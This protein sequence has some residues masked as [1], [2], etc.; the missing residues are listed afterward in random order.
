[1]ID[2]VAFGSFFN[3]NSLNPADIKSTTVLKDATAT[4]IYGS[5]GANGVVLITTKNGGSLKKPHE[6]SEVEGAIIEL[7]LKTGINQQLIP[8]YD[9]ITSPEEYV[10]LVW[11]GL[12]NRGV[13][14]DEEDPV[15]FANSRLLGSNGI[16]DGYNMWNVSSAAELID[17]QTRTV[18]PGVR[19]LFTPEHYADEAFG[20]GVRTEANINVSGASKKTR[21]YTSIGYLNDEGYSINSD[22]T[23]YSLRLNT[24]S[25]L[26]DWLNVGVNIGY[27]YSESTNNGQIQGSENVFEFADKMAPI[28]P[29][30]ARLPGTGTLIPDPVYGGYQYDYGS[31]TGTIN[32]FERSRPNANLLN[33]IGSARFDF[34]GRTTNALNGSVFTH[35]N[36]LSDLKLETTFGGQYSFNRRQN[37]SNHVYGTGRNPNGTLEVRDR[38]RWSRT[39]TNLLR[40]NKSFDDHTIEGLVAYETFEVGFSQSRQ[41]KKDVIV[42]GLYNLSNYSLT[43]SPSDGYNDNSGIESVFGQLN[44][45]YLGKYYFTGSVRRDGSSRFVNNKWGTFGSVGLAWL[46]SAENFMKESFLTYLKLKASYGITGDQDG[47]S[48]S[49]G[50]TIYNSD[51]IGG[52]LSL[53]EN[54]PGYADLTWERSRMIQ[55]G[56]EASIGPRFDLNIEYYSK[57]TD[58]LFFNRRV[59]PSSGFSSVLVN[60]GKIVNAGLEFDLFGRVVNSDNFKLDVSVNGELL[61]NKFTQ[62]PIDPSTGRAKVIDTG[63]SLDSG[64]YAFA[65]GKSQFDFYTREWAGV[66]STDGAPMWYQYYDDRNDNGMLDAGDVSEGDSWAVP[67]NASTNSSSTLF[68]YKKLVS[69][70]NIKRTTTKTYNSATQVFLNKSFIP[71]IRGAFRISARYKNFS[72][73]T[74]FTYSFGGYAYDGQYAELMSD[75]FGAAGNNYHKDILKRWQRPGDQTNI[76]LLSDNAITNSTSGSSRF[77]ISTDFVAL[78]NARIGYA[79]NNKLTKN[80]GLVGLN[81]WISGDNLFIKTK[82]K[83]FNPN[84]REVGSSGRRIYAPATTITMGAKIKF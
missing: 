65:E 57:S 69:D 82:R 6:S 3:L 44:Y 19:R 76:P 20:T 10:G 25:K 49:R 54:R 62:M 75:R 50:Y 24:N 59:G 77:I 16:S 68:E 40:Y 60:D 78:N 35:I 52:G 5:R 2:G 11:E 48:T 13:N 83:G 58:N 30:F 61:K 37:T 15:A 56:V 51:Y 74:Q 34:D 79:M 81:L 32:G 12:Y 17:P 42:P 36:I 33:P 66:D 27:A 28:Y 22:Y 26:K 38:I 29:V 9:V 53:A 47:V 45:N 72:L 71:D 84:I 8:R 23:R 41:F 1:M 4:A 55:R 80:L 14:T 64:L 46:A 73:S 39:F 70:A 21:Y 7:E 31:P 63:S 18:R 67:G 43:D